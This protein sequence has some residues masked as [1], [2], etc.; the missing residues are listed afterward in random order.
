ML[1]TKC[2]NSRCRHQHTAALAADGHLPDV[3]DLEVAA[4]AAYGILEPAWVVQRVMAPPG[5]SMVTPMAVSAADPTPTQPVH[6]PME[7]EQQ[8]SA[9]VRISITTSGTQCSLQ[10]VPT[11]ADETIALSSA[12]STS[13][14]SDAE[15]DDQDDTTSSD[16]N[17]GMTEAE[18]LTNKAQVEEMMAAAVADD[19]NAHSKVNIATE[20]VC[21]WVGGL[22]VHSTTDDMTCV[23]TLTTA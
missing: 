17:V 18:Y 5:E 15:D 1:P 14:S 13:S 6:A 20:L 22:L 2:T 4:A 9:R 3:D 12:S 8:Q 16:S 19:V 7:E 21:C 23:C 10:L 11:T